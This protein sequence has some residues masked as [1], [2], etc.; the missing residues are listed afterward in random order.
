M[1]GFQTIVENSRPDIQTSF[2]LER[3]EQSLELIKRYQPWRYRH[4]RRDIER[5]LIVRYPCRGAY[6]PDE[7]TCMTELTFLARSDMTP[8]QIAASI[9][10]EGMHARMHNMRM[11]GVGLAAESWDRPREERI[12]RRSEYDFGLALPPELGA[13]VVQ[14][15]QATLMASDNDVAPQID[16]DEA[17]RRQD[18]ADLEAL[19]LPSWLKRVLINFRSWRS[20]V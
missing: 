10:H 5:F 20:Q 11:N 7:R 2:V 13:P 3:L 8:A 6:F 4:L 18:I 12:C 15:A 14:R 1:D 9:V 19:D 16:W 17:R